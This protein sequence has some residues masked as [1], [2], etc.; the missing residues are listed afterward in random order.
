MNVPPPKKKSNATT[1]GI[2]I[3]PKIIMWVEITELLQSISVCGS[4]PS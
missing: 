2:N 4:P 1:R 3:P